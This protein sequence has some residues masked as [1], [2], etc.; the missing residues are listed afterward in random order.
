MLMPEI[1]PLSHLPL[2]RLSPSLSHSLSLSLSLSNTHT[3]TLTPAP[4]R[5]GQNIVEPPKQ[6]KK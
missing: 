3:H 4:T 2:A 1:I 6:T 5:K